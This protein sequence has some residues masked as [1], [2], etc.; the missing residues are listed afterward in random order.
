MHYDYGIPAGME[1][2]IF[3]MPWEFPVLACNAYE[4]ATHPK[5]TDASV[6]AISDILQNIAPWIS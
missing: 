6:R 1:S 2:R 4:I 3:T 5:P